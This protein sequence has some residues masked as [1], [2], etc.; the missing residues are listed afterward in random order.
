MSPLTQGFNYRSGCDKRQSDHTTLRTSDV[1]PM[2]QHVSKNRVVHL[3]FLSP[4]TSN[5]SGRG[6]EARGMGTG[7]SLPSRL[8]SAERRIKLPQRGLERSCSRRRF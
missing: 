2:A 6:V 1:N 3:F 4:Q 7:C 5:Y 8:R